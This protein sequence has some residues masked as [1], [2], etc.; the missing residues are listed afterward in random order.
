MGINVLSELCKRASA[1][2]GVD[3]DVEIVEQ[4]HHN[5]L[6]PDVTVEQMGDT[7]VGRGAA[8]AEANLVV[9]QARV[10]AP[11]GDLRGGVQVEELAARILEHGARA[12]ESPSMP[13][14]AASCP[15]TR[16]APESSPS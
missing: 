8:N 3:Y 10:L 14:S 9:R 7:Q 5:K 2:L 16:T 6:D 13:K 1:I 11:E 15:S 4:H 12:Q